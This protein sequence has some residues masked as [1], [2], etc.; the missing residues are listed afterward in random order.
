MIAETIRRAFKVAW[1]PP[2]GPT[3]A[4][5][6]SDYIGEQVR[7]EVISQ[8]R[9]D[10]RMRVR[11]NPDEVQR[12]ARLLVEARRPLLIVGDE[13]YKARASGKAVDLAELLGLPVT[14]ARQVY[15][16]FPQD[17]PLWVGGDARHPREHAGVSRSS[18][19]SSSTSATSCSTTR[20]APMVPRS[21]PFIDM[22]ID[23]A[24]MGNVLPTAV[25]LVADVAYGMDDLIAAV[26]DVLTPAIETRIRER[27]AEVRGVQRLGPAPA[28]AGREEPR[29]GSASAPRGP[30]DL[31]GGAVGGPRTRSSSTRPARWSSRTASSSIRSGDGSCSSTTARTSGRAW[32]SRPAS[33]S[34]GRASR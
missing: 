4:T 32:A 2:Y 16:S 26:K 23:G 9:V 11:P 12:A 30:S 22:R 28:A 34:P 21:T 6:H 10:P 8:Q 25:P 27:A 19:T 14:Q 3:Y 15:A 5:W 1:T 33:S 29:L 31:R 18:P 24:S 20:R 17:H 13:V 7:T